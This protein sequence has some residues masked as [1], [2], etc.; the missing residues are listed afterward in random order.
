MPSPTLELPRFN[1]HTSNKDIKHSDR[2]IMAR[3]GFPLV[4]IIKNM[5]R[6]AGR[7]TIIFLKDIINNF[8]EAIFYLMIIHFR[9]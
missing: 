9:I 8:I 3:A 6:M 1:A 4:I 7:R 2:V 5:N